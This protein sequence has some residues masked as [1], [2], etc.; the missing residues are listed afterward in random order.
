MSINIIGY[1][2]KY[3][4]PVI[5]GIRW[6]TSI[7]KNAV[8]RALH[9]ISNTEQYI[10]VNIKQLI[11]RNSTTSSNMQLIYYPPQPDLPK[12]LDATDSK[13]DTVLLRFR[14]DKFNT[15]KNKF[16]NLRDVELWFSK[17]DFLE[18]FGCYLD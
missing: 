1:D 5:R 14:D 12:E 18:V 4:K 10:E 13:N 6:D 7:D 3:W 17:E 2:K 9:V 8:L 16:E 15:L 11:T